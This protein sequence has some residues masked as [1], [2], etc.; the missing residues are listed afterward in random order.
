[1]F[2]QNGEIV[3]TNGRS[4]NAQPH[5]WNAHK[6]TVIPMNMPLVVLVNQYSASASEIF[7]GAMRDLHRGLIVGHRSFGK[8][9][10]QNLLR[11]GNETRPDGNPEAMMKLTMAY[12]YLPNG[13]SLHRRDGAKTWGV[14]PDVVVDL[15]PKQIF[16][17]MQSRRDADIIH[18]NGETAATRPEK[19]PAATTKAAPSV[20]TQ[21]DTAVLM[22]RLQLVQATP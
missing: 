18:R 22:M 4:R 21:L 11:I 14:D 19:A 1:M 16:D 7:S 5:K 2:L 6:D 10:V 15:T 3:S 9:S 20:D 12:Y 13:E 8:G 17:L